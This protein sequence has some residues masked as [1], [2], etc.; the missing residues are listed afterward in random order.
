LQDDLGLGILFISHD[1]AVV[2]SICDHLLVMQHGRSLEFGPA[3]R[4]LRHPA[5]AYTQTL[6]KAAGVST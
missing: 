5:H 6:L 3:A 4:V 1:L 2:A